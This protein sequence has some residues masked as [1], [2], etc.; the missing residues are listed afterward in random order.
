MKCSFDNNL[1]N[2]IEIAKYQYNLIAG[3]LGLAIGT[4]FYSNT[5]KRYKL[6][7]GIDI[8]RWKIR[9]TR[10]L[11]NEEN[12]NWKEAKKFLKPKVISQVLIAHIENPVPNIKITACYDSEG[13]IITNTL[14][15]LTCPP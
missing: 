2:K 6:L 3:E 1:F 7:K 15:S 4:S 8:E 5:R 11:S 14:T 13:I 9:N 10:Y 12:I